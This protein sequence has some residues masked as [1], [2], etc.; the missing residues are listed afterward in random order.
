MT[1]IG[2]DPSS[3][4]VALVGVHE[5]E[6]FRKSWEAPRKEKSRSAILSGFVTP[7][8]NY[9]R[10]LTDEDDVVWMFVED[11]VVGVGGPRPTIVQA[12]VQGL[13]L[14]LARYAGA[15]G[16]YSVNVQ[17]WKKD[18]VGNGN[19][20]KAEVAEWLAERHP[21]LSELA[22]EDQDFVDAACIALYG[23]AVIERGERFTG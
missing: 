7:F 6:W 20:S 16:A 14:G 18:V 21:S 17:T 3:R 2:I 11:P 5:N 8:T 10:E 15:N 23:V 9:I 22:G 12:Q 19:S 1:V 4:K 13:V